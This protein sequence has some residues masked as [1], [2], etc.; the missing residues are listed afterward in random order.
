VQ[1][2][3]QTLLDPVMNISFGACEA[4]GGASGVATWDA[5]FSQAASE[6]ISVF[7]SSAD[8]GA[9]T[10]DGAFELAPSYQFLSINYICASSYAT[11]VGGTQLVDTAN[12]SQYWSATNSSNLA[13]A[14]SY[15]PEGAWNESTTYQSSL[16]GYPIVAGGGGASVYVPKPSWQTGAGVPAD[17]ARDVPDVSFPSASHDGYY[18]CYA[19]D[20]GDCNANRFLY[21]AGT[22][23]AAPAMAGIAAILNQKMGTAQGNLNPLLYH[24]AASNPNVFHDSTPASSGVANCTVNVPSLCNNSLPSP[25]SLTGGLAGYAVT[26]GYDL[27][28]GLGSLDVANFLAAASSTSHPGVA[29]TLLAVHGSATTISYTQTTTF[30]ATV[31]SNTP[32]VPTGTVQFYSDGN[33]LGAPVNV[34]S[35][36]ATTAALPFTSAGTYYITA[37]YSGDSKYAASTAPGFTLTVTGLSSSA[38]VMASNSA[39]PIGTNA[40]FSVTVAGG[41]GSPKPTGS[42]W[43]LVHGTKN[44]DYFGQVPLMNGIATTP[45][46][47]FPAMGSYTATAQYLGD[48]VYSPSTSAPLTFTITK[49]PSTTTLSYSWIPQN[50]GIGGGMYYAASARPTTTSTGPNLTGTLQYYVNGV[51][52]GSPF[53]LSSTSPPT[54][55]TFPGPGTYSVTA[56]YSGDSNWLPSTSNAINQTVVL[57]PATFTIGAGLNNSSFTAGETPSTEVNVSPVLG[58]FGTVNLTCTVTYNGGGAANAPTCGLSN[59]SVTI[60]S[61]QWGASVLTIRSVANSVAGSPLPSLIHSGTITLCGLGLWLI[62]VRRRN[63][64]VL[65]VVLISLASLTAVSGCG[66]TGSS[67]STPTTLGS[68]TLTLSATTTVT[69]VT[70]PAPLTMA[71]TVK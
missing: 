29:V 38:T 48:A 28:T 15:I 26:A 23:V 66:G 35:G 20:G 44:G 65:A 9:A 55:V 50:I 56:L 19:N 11:C 17:H 47:N 8:S 1:Y 22:S 25:N 69:G 12:P 42:V 4:Y 6:G 14:L 46:L 60:N 61:P 54:P 49:G 57:Q 21:F 16:G 63:W 40:T 7:V 70:P 71:L 68:Y 30:T 64:R 18:I 59:S 31:S 39:I 43:F 36:T 33:A 34:S 51:S 62:P 32:G 24:L 5:L 67:G 53:D 41:S 37:V 27:A 3:V 52:Q 13:S 2:E 58:F 45:S 10:C